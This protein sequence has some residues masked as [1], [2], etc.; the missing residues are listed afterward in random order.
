MIRD[1]YY[2]MTELCK[3]DLAA[4]KKIAEAAAS[5]AVCLAADLFFG[6]TGNFESEKVKLLIESEFSNPNSATEKLINSMQKD[7]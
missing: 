4:N 2:N 6:L 1:Y 3:Q 7:A 5:D